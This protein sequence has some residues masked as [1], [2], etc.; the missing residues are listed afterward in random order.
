M[1]QSITSPTPLL[2]HVMKEMSDVK[3]RSDELSIPGERSIHQAIEKLERRLNRSRRKIR[4]KKSLSEFGFKEAKMLKKYKKV[5][6]SS[7]SSH[8]ICNRNSLLIKQARKCM[9]IGATLD[10]KYYGGERETIKKY[11]IELE[12]GKISD[13]EIDGIVDGAFDDLEECASISVEF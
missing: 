10:V 1:Y 7:L 8:A 11:Y 13:K 4:K 6:T 12:E 9:D 5:P 2:R 3:D